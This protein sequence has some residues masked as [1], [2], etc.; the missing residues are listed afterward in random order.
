[1]PTIYKLSFPSRDTCKVKVPIYDYECFLYQDCSFHIILFYHETL[2]RSDRFQEGKICQ[3]N[4]HI[5][6]IA[7]NYSPFLNTTM[8]SETN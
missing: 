4:T 3:R 8:K 2:N 5:L 1:M 6:K 7:K